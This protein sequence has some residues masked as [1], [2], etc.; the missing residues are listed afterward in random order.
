[1]KNLLLKNSEDKLW[2]YWGA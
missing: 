1:M 2:N